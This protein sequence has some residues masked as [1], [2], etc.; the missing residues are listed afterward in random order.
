M[1]K[2]WEHKNLNDAIMEI[3][4]EKKDI[5]LVNGIKALFSSKPRAPV[6]ALRMPEHR[7]WQDTC[8]M[9]LSETPD[10]RTIHWFYGTKGNEGKSVYSKNKFIEDPENVILVTQFNGGANAANL[11]SNALDSGWSGRTMIMNL[12]RKQEFHE[13]YATLENIKDGVITNTKYSAKSIVI[14]NPHVIVFANF[15]PHLFDDKGKLT[16][17]MDRWC[18]YEILEDYTC[19]RRSKDEIL[20]VLTHI[21][22]SYDKDPFGRD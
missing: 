12:S 2:V 10:E 14:D 7:P 17:S 4:T 5:G 22:G 11:I 18:V 6:R 8:D 16:M 13:I 21:E 9:I 20:A 3:V 1:S 19:V 15:P